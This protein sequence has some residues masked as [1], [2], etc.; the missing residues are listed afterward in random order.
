MTLAMTTDFANTLFGFVAD[1]G[2]LLALDVSFDDF[3]RHLILLKHR[4]ADLGFFAVQHQQGLEVNGLTGVL[5][6]LN[7]KR[8]AFFDEVLLA[9]GRDYCL[10]HLLQIVKNLKLPIEHT[11][12]PRPCKE[13]GTILHDLLPL[14]YIDDIN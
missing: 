13:S 2:H 8:L 11:K 3:G 4:R 14:W 12:N 1:S 7:F 5:Q 6:Q 9:A 10:F